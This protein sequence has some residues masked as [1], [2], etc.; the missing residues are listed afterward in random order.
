[1]K[2]HANVR[3]LMVMV[4]VV[5]VVQV[6]SQRQVR[7]VRLVWPLVEPEWA[8]VVLTLMTCQ[9]RL[10]VAHQTESVEHSSPQQQ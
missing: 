1:M 7:H 5:V 9:V 10:G 8:E 2:M 6:H 3:L 4:Q